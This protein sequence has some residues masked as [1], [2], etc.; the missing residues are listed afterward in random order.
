MLCARREHEL[1]VTAAEC[2][3]MGVR[4]ET[5]IVDVAEREQVQAFADR[6]I[7]TLGQVDVWINNAGTDAFG[8]FVDMPLVAIERYLHV[9]L[10]GRIYGMKAILPHFRER[11]GGIIINN[12]PLVGVV[13]TPF[14]LRPM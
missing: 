9:N 7:T 1:E 5:M 10:F 11:G 8:E 6:A 14:S 3:Q 13:P 4:I 12:A 2:R